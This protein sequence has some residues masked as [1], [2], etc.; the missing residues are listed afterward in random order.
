MGDI[1][2]AHLGGLGIILIPCMITDIRYRI[3]PPLYMGGC[4]IAAVLVNRF[5]LKMDGWPML[6]GV[7]LGL[8]FIGI[9]LMSHGD[10]GLGDGILVMVLGAWCGFGTALF[11]T[12][13]AM[14][15]AMIVGI[16]TVSLKKDSFKTELPFAPFFSIPWV[17][18]VILKIAEGGGG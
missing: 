14:V 1:S 18:L 2:W 13:I 4:L 17:F 16:I 7:I 6:F 3:I 15:C 10:I 9:S 12:F 8:A 5:V 11:M